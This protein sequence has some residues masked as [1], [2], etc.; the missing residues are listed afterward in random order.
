MYVVLAMQILQFIAAF[1]VALKR[2]TYL[3][4]RKNRQLGD[5]T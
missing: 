3:P 5:D 4:N 2:F 1:G